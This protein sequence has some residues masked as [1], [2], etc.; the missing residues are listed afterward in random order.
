MG[1]FGNNERCISFKQI[2]N[3]STLFHHCEQTT[4]DHTDVV[5]VIIVEYFDVF[6]SFIQTKGVGL[7]SH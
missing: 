3:V 5:K 2:K 6:F 7:N 4:Q 1:Y